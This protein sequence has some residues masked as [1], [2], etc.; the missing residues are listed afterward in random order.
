MELMTIDE[1]SELLRV[2]RNKVLLMAKRGEIPAFLFC[3]RLR[4][5]AQEVE[6]WLKENR[7]K[8]DVPIRFGS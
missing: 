1:L 4:F 6:T 2:S 5:D 7:F 3:G 8:P